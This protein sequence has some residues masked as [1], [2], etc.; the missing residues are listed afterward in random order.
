[1]H[2]PACRVNK[3]GALIANIAEAQE[4][5]D[6]KTDGTEAVC[7]VEAKDGSKVWYENL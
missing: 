1:V 3:V 5:A 4:I 7:Y 6:K 2:A